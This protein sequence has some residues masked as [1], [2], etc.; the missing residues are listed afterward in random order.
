MARRNGENWY[1]AG[2][3]DWNARE[4]KACLDFLGDGQYEAEI[5]CD[6]VNAD[7][8]AEDYRIEKV[9]VSKGDVLDVKMAN[10]GGWAAV[11][12]KVK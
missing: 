11:I 6:G 8:W 3:N 5:F 4:L 2:M 9:M 7:R 1:V 12:R 10:G